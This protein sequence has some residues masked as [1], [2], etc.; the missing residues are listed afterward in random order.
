MLTALVAAALV[1]GAGGAAVVATTGGSTS[2]VTTRI[3]TPTASGSTQP[4]SA[5]STAVLSP[6]EVYDRAKGSV[7]YIT[8]QIT[9]SASP[10]WGQQQ[11]GEATGSGFVVSD[12]GYIVT[13]A[14]V[15]DGAS[16]VTVK[17]GDRKAVKAKIVGAD[18]STDVALLKI[19]TGGEKLTPLTLGDSDAVNVGDPVYAIGN[20][21]G[22]SRTLT[23]GVVSA[24]QRQ[25]TSPNNWTISNVIQTDAALNPGNS[26]GPL[27]DDTGKVIGINSQIE[28]GTGSSESGNVGIGFA[29]PI[30]TVKTVIAQLKAT[31]HAKHAYLGVSTTDTEDDSGATVAA[32]QSGGPADK[33]GIK[34][35]DK[36]VALGGTTVTDAADLGAAVDARHAGDEVKVELKRG[37]D[38]KTITVKLGTR[39]EKD[40]TS[41]DSSNG[42][43]DQG[44]FGFGAP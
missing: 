39:P 17:V 24:L 19:D 11:Q 15:V 32:V 34:S 40:I 1:G 5:S 16:S 26:G 43:G 20:P 9:E 13:N 33:A 4:V 27:F 12:D 37:G 2:T 18:D 23:T 28:T 29:V 7:A 22:L 21:F 35:G 3:E 6:R 42:Y 10:F 38:A 30:N 36:I 14:H 31:G 41:S 44:G 8:S 25:I